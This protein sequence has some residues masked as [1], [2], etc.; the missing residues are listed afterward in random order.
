MVSG[1]WEEPQVLLPAI[2]W[3][4]FE[5]IESDVEHPSDDE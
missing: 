3:I 1:D 4:S 5:G 2:C